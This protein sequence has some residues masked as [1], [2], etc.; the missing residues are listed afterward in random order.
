MNP[1]V[2]SIFIIW[3]GLVQY[4]IFMKDPDDFIAEYTNLNK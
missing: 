2:K 1:N 3:T 4:P